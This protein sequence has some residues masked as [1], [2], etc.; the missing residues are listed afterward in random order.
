MDARAHDYRADD[1][2]PAVYDIA[3][4]LLQAARL[5]QEPPSL[6]EHAQEAV[7]WI[8]RAIIELE[9]DTP[10][11]AAALADGLGR[12]LVTYVFTDVARTLPAEPG[13]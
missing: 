2:L 5:E 7:R 4:A 11:S 3:G 9:Q 12:M 10:D 1:W 6:V 13:A 8:S